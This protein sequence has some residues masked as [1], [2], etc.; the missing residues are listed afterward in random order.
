MRM[1]RTYVLIIALT[2]MLTVYDRQMKGGMPKDL[3]F[4]VL[5]ALEAWTEEMIY[6]FVNWGNNP[7]ED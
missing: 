6:G 7:Y 2:L 4:R 5:H 3:F 1:G